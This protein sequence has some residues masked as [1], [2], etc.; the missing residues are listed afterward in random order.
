[1]EYKVVEK[2][3]SVNGEGPL[4]G[5]L[6]VFIRF[7]GCNLN[8]SYC[9]TTWANEKDASY[10]LMTPDDIYEYIKSTQ[11]RNVTLTGGEPLLQ[12][13]IIE[14]LNVLSIDNS[15]HIEIETNGSINLSKFANIEN[16]PS[17]NM[18]YKLPSSNMEGPMDLNNF[19]YLTYKDTV[20]FVASSIE[21]LQ[22]SKR[23]IDKYA[24]TNKTNVYISPVFGQIDLEKIVEFMKSNKMNGVNLQVQL[25]KIIWDPNKRGV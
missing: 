23:I 10:N 2:F 18:D 25:H 21:D 9:D 11:I 3:I 24:L 20:K 22:K 14:L 7:A 15:I 13:G 4:S 19:A 8:C 17:F 6:V 16:P 12:E 5:Q 1:M